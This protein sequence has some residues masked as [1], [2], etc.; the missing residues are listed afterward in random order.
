[1]VRG[2][3]RASGIF[4][5]VATLVAACGGRVATGPARGSGT[6][7]AFDAQC[8][9]GRCSA[10]AQAGGCGVCLDARR[11]GEGC[12]GARDVCARSARCEAGVCVSNKKTEGASCALGM[13]GLLPVDL[14]ECDDELYCAPA[15]TFV[16]T[17]TCRR[18]VAGGAACVPLVERCVAGFDC[19]SATRTCESVASR[20]L[21]QP[22]GGAPYCEDG[23]ECDPVAKRCQIGTLP[24]GSPCG[25][26]NG[27]S[28]DRACAPGLVCGAHQE[29]CVVA[30]TEQQPC[31]TL[32]CAEGLF[33]H[34]F[35]PERN[36]PATCERPRGAGEACAT[37][38]TYAVP[39]ADG[40]ECRAS[41]CRPACR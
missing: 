12:T 11:L 35:P 14:G 25:I 29:G 20:T 33:C 7:C 22:C 5:C 24:Q 8:P 17:G 40:L 28:V 9:S 38:S 26:V 39:C 3:L 10:D 13:G 6:A 4:A 27:Q 36:K 41:V 18:F 15:S 34:G 21:G 32:R 37:N 1:M 31:A 30:P 23:L 2:P 19:R 16:R